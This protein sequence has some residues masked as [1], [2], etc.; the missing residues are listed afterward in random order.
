MS[1]APGGTAI[2]AS[3]ALDGR[4]IDK[5]AFYGIACDPARSVAVEAC[6]GSGKTWLLVSRMLRA[7]L[8]PVLEGVPGSASPVEPHQ[9]LAVTFT[10]KAAG[11]MRA[12]LDTLLEECTVA[13]D[14]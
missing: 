1:S 13:N 4:A 3:Y 10:R 8:A 7:L 2:L 12:R 9:I 5:A 14:D 11:E 6:A